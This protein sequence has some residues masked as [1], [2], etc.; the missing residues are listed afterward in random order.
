[1]RIQPSIQTQVGIATPAQQIYKLRLSK[2][3]YHN[4]KIGHKD[5]LQIVITDPE[6]KL[7]PIEFNFSNSLCTSDLKG[8]EKRSRK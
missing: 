4:S 2:L 6:S 7:N 5:Q 8:C 3:N 1:M